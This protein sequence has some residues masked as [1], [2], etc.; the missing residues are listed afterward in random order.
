MSIPGSSSLPLHL[1][2]FVN[3]ADELDRFR[4][5][6]EQPLEARRERILIF[7]GPAGIGKTLL[8]DRIA[9]ECSLRAIPMARISFEGGQK[10]DYLR[11]MRAIR[12]QL[13]AADFADWTELVNYYY[14]GRPMAVLTV[15]VE[16]APGQSQVNIQAENV[17]VQGDIVGGN[18]I[19]IRDNFIVIPRADVDLTLIQDSLTDKF[20]EVVGRFV[21]SKPVFFLF[22]SV[23]HDDFDLLTR[24][25][26]WQNLID[27]ASKLGGLGLVPVIALVQR[28]RLERALEVYTKQQELKPLSQEHV[29]EYLRR[30]GVPAELV[31]G[32]ASTILVTTDCS[33]DQVFQVT[34][35]LLERLAQK[36]PGR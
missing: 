13:D 33:P 14:P 32:A 7:H 35:K 18:K 11:I 2:D 5:L 3:R 29:E 22:D 4:A 6:V 8:L 12:D 16:S 20:I 24:Q 10:N 31:P 19:E 23:D 15:R 28:P 34:E 26:L 1:F 36:G 27:R 25:W 17:T 9:H 30:R 21:Q